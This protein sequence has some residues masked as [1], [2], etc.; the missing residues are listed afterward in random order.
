[1]NKFKRAAAVAAMVGGL[2]L[3]GGG[4]ASANGG[5]Y[6]DV[7]APFAV[8]NLQVVECEQEFDGGLAFAPV[9]TAVTGDVE[10]NIG[11]FCTVI[12]SID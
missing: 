2:G 11:N 12:G 10:Q 9:A 8:D 5:D 4:V 7:P 6:Y 3:A 1:M